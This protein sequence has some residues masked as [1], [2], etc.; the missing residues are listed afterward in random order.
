MAGVKLGK[1][2]A[3]DKDEGSNKRISYFIKPDTHENIFAIDSKNGELTSR[4]SLDR[5]EKKYYDLVIVAIDFGQ[6]VR[7]TGVC[8][9]KVLVDDVND[10]API[11]LPPKKVFASHAQDHT[12]I[13]SLI[14]SHHTNHSSL[15]PP[16]ASANPYFFSTSPS[17]F[18]SSSYKNA[19]VGPFVFYISNR[20]QRADV[21][22][23]MVAS[24]RDANENSEISFEIISSIEKRVLKHSKTNISKHSSASK[25]NKKQIGVNEGE[26]GSGGNNNYGGDESEVGNELHQ[27]GHIN[28]VYNHS[29]PSSATLREVGIKLI[30][31]QSKNQYK[32]HQPPQTFLR[33]S[34]STNLSNVSN[35]QP[36]Q[37]IFKSNH[38]HHFSSQLQ[39]HSSVQHTHN[40]KAPFSINR[41]NG[42]IYLLEENFNKAIGKHFIL[43]IM[44]SDKGN[45]S[46]SSTTHLH[47]IVNSSLSRNGAPIGVFELLTNQGALAVLVAVV[48][49]VLCSICLVICLMAMV[50]ACRRY[51]KSKKLACKYS[52]AATQID[53][54]CTRTSTLNKDIDSFLFPSLKQPTGQNDD[55]N[56]HYNHVEKCTNSP[57]TTPTSPETASRK[58]TTSTYNWSSSYNMIDTNIPTPVMAEANTAACNITAPSAMV[59]EAKGLDGGFNYTNVS[60]ACFKNYE[61]RTENLSTFL[62]VRCACCNCDINAR[63]LAPIMS[64]IKHL[65]QH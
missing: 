48:V 23:R 56:K 53:K 4:K 6:P 57:N 16:S 44:A 7:Q 31:E 12:S 42:D 33:N 13:I 64:I 18:Y 9:V 46:L 52:V 60:F 24:D 35:F 27:N 14:P 10:N 38:Q 55:Y 59:E 21:V 1:V 40:Q 30:E 15:F 19:S 63:R 8:E 28:L 45:Y 36:H 47:L 50:L 20:L 2:T 49:V 43:V 11:F 37:N 25:S 5:E 39:T 65:L 54:N 62:K 41:D 29:H 22:V 32:H 26:S 17:S 3:I 34:L 51:C 61:R 58:T